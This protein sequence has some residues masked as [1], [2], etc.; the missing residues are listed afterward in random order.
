MSIEEFAKIVREGNVTLIIDTNVLLNLYRLPSKV[1]ESFILGYR[2][3]TNPKKI[4]W[5]VKQEYHRNEGHI[6]DDSYNSVKQTLSQTITNISA[7]K[8]KLKKYQTDLK[9]ADLSSEL[10][11]FL[12]ID[13]QLTQ[14]EQSLNSDK[15]NFDTMIM[16]NRPQIQKISDFITEIFTT[17]EEIQKPSYDVYI[18]QMVNGYVR[19]KHH[20]PPGYEDFQNKYH[21]KKKNAAEKKGMERFSLKPEELTDYLGDYQI[22]CSILD[23]GSRNDVLFVTGDL[24]SDWWIVP[25]SK[26]LEEYQPRNE[27]LM[28]FSA[29]N[30]EK[31]VDLLPLNL[32]IYY[33]IALYGQEPFESY[34]LSHGDE[35]L[36]NE[37]LERNN[38]LASLFTRQLSQDE[39]ASNGMLVESTNSFDLVTV[40]SSS[41]EGVEIIDF[42]EIPNSEQ[43]PKE[44]LFYLQIEVTAEGTFELPL[45]IEGEVWST[46]IGDFSIESGILEAEVTVGF[47][48]G[49]AEFEDIPGE[50]ISIVDLDII[51]MTLTYFDAEVY[52]VNVDDGFDPDDDYDRCRD[53][54]F[55]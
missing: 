48:I 2:Q 27:L 33:V 51:N 12:E 5:V 49:N 18:K 25:K 37:L 17:H 22:W 30:Q 35:K 24:K 13:G 34:F 23:E 50:N 29:V 3:L 40:S 16:T 44:I 46:S 32:F 15:E 6:K 8:D 45:V 21:A 55:D 53:M 43:Y 31:S 26:K 39:R 36:S 10:D 52:D 54:Y 1:V 38:E 14:L 47:Y 28:E 11:D 4:S 9:K 20:F 19:A 42:S 7:L 41:I